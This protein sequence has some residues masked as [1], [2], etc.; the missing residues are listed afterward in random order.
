M[1]T[2]NKVCCGQITGGSHSRKESFDSCS[3]LSRSQTLGHF[4]YF[5]NFFFWGG[6]YKLISFGW[7]LYVIITLEVVGIINI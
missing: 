3:Q 4:G 7:N 5:V 6:G 2:F 1:T